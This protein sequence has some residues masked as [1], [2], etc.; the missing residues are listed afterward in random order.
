[1][2]APHQVVTCSVL[3]LRR[4]TIAGTARSGV[5]AAFPSATNLTDCLSTTRWCSP[6]ASRR[7]GATVDS[8]RYCLSHATSR[9]LMT[10][11]FPQQSWTKFMMQVAGQVYLGAS[12][13]DANP[14]SCQ[15]A[16]ILAQ[17]PA[18]VAVPD[19][20]RTCSPRTLRKCSRPRRHQS[21][22]RRQ[23]PPLRRLPHVR[24]QPSTCNA[25]HTTAHH[26]E[27]MLTKRGHVA[28]LSFACHDA[29][30]Y[31]ALLCLSS[32][33]DHDCMLSTSKFLRAAVVRPVQPAAPQP[34]PD[35]ATVPEGRQG[36]RWRGL[37][38]RSVSPEPRRQPV[39]APQEP[40][41]DPRSQAILDLR[42]RAE[43]ITQKAARP[44]AR[45][46]QADLQEALQV[47]GF[48]HI[49]LQP[50]LTVEA[51]NYSSSLVP[52]CAVM[53]CYLER[54]LVMRAS[55]QLRGMLELA[56]ESRA[57][58]DYGALLQDARLLR[59]DIAQAIED[60]EIQK[61]QFAQRLSASRE[62]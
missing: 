19:P 61:V 52:H 28:R 35:V 32:S 11:R 51:T 10:Q 7:G 22:Q 46:E 25:W 37:R 6:A 20:V 50:E 3:V 34:Q 47:T 30:F 53:Q 9:Y 4:L 24:Y 54:S 45:D 40:R 31:N 41:T 44:A 13:A 29:R 62:P 14:R 27:R 57:H 59:R 16:G 58:A 43:E 18:R 23:L 49:A 5:P 2:V 39:A 60:R 33:A 56:Q 1:M 21:Q 8:H 48:S 26:H 36:R 55:Q 42:R 12:W 15:M 38:G 17:C